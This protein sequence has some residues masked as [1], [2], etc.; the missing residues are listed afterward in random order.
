[1]DVGDDEEEAGAVHVDVADRPSRIHVA[2]DVLDG[3]EGSVGARIIPHRQ[4]DAGDDLDGEE[5]A[6]EDAEVPP[7]IEVARNRIT[8]ADRAIDQARKR[9]P[10]VQPAH[11]RGFRFVGFCP[12]EAHVWFFPLSR[13]GQWCRKRIHS[14]ERPGWSVPDRCGCA[15]PCRRPN[16]GTGRN[17]R[18]TDRG[19]RPRRC[20]AARSRG[21]CRRPSVI[22]QFC[23]PGLVRS[24]SVCGSRSSR[25][26]H[27]IRGLDFL[28][29]QVADEHRL[30]APDG[31]DGLARRD[32]R[33]VDFGL[34]RARARRP[35][36][37]S[38]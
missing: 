33:N 36:G 1:M 19:S 16:R 30:L 6:G 15:P 4:H 38:A 35:A 18:R 9:K 21:A 23:L 13:Y 20:P 32:L 24:A 25:N 11:E 12:G 3:I 37:P 29:R 2:H 7:V 14:P 27:R 28:R 22:S 5:Q 26:W 31:L 17:S 10:L 34:T 8:A